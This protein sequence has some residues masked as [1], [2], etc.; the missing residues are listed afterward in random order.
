M[1]QSNSEIENVC[2]YEYVCLAYE[3]DKARTPLQ[4]V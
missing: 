3:I 1:K 4:M 2:V